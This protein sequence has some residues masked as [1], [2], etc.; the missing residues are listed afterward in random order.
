MININKII[1]YYKKSLYEDHKQILKINISNSSHLKT[2][3]LL[4]AFLLICYSVNLKKQWILNN[5]NFGTLGFSKVYSI[6]F[7]VSSYEFPKEK[8]IKNMKPKLNKRGIL[9]TKGAF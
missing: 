2:T 9:T 3:L 7:L 5:V 4:H 1:E 6:L 8:T